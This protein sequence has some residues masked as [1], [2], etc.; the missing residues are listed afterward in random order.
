M[1]AKLRQ[2]KQCFQ[3]YSPRRFRDNIHKPRV[4]VVEKIS[5]YQGPRLKDIREDVIKICGIRTLRVEYRSLMAYG[6]KA[7]KDIKK[8]EYVA[9]IRRKN[10]G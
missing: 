6:I 5:N 4:V 9:M 10:N 7:G 2:E 3:S 8:M 1:K